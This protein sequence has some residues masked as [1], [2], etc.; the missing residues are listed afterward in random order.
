MTGKSG[1]G[2]YLLHQQELSADGRAIG[3][4]RYGRSYNESAV[5]EQQAGAHFLLYEP[6]F[7]TN[8]KH[9][10]VGA[11]FKFVITEGLARW[12]LATGTTLLDGVITRLGGVFGW[13]FLAYLVFWSFFVG[14]ALMSAC[15][16]TLH[17]LFPVFDD[18]GTGKIVFGISCSLLGWVLVLAGGYSLFE[19]I[20]NVCIGLMFLT[21]VATAVVLWP[22]VENVLRFLEGVTV[23]KVIVVPGKLVNIVAN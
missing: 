13:L 6:G 15:G 11:A 2:F 8:L 7:A 21:V 10:V 20:M 4:A 23:R 3:I 19:K 22:G 5:F 14:S 12:Q 17:A 16:V 9:D 1:W 18:A